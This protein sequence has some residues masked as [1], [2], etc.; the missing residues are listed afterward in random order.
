MQGKRTV[1]IISDAM[2]YEV[3]QKL[4][5]NLADDHKC[6]AKLDKQL[7]V[8]PSYTRLG[9]AALLPHDDI[10][11][12]DDYRVL[13]DDV[14]CDNLLGRQTVLQ[15]HSPN[16]ICV[17]FD[18]I[19][20]LKKAELRDIFTG[21]QIIYIYHNQIDAR[22]D[23]A[24]TYHFI[25]TADHGFI[26]KR[27]KVTESDKISGVN[28]K[29][30]FVNR[31]FI[32]ADNAVNEDGITSIS[33]GRVLRNQDTKVISFPISSNVFKVSG[34]GQN[35]VHGGSSPQE[36]LVPVLDVKMER[37]HMDTKNASIALISMV[38]KITNKVTMLDFLQSEPVSDTIK[39]TKYKIFFISEANEKIS[40]EISFFADSREADTQ[41]R[42]FRMKF[43]F[44]D[45]RYDKDK[46][47]YLVVL[48]E[49]TG[50][51]SFRH[52][53][54]MDLVFEDVF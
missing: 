40:N 8:L 16:S 54:I 43:Q 15:K 33:I 10:T 47:Y 27:D 48:D 17:Q 36:M 6:R 45:K 2:R 28:D 51:E 22:G 24:N 18:D 34:G 11:M 42:I 14:L 38:Q 49:S 35:F 19:K 3:G 12:T 20:N 21:K 37:G 7:S 9:M 26:Y 5:N 46:K 50:E 23:K 4:Y 53:V 25:I 39:A 29:N 31:R 30:A 44:K 13:V 52:M 41:K 1:V 32:V